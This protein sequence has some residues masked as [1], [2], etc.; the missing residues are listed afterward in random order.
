[1]IIK[2]LSTQA[3]IYWEILKF[4]ATQADE[5]DKADLQPYLNELLHALLSDKA[6]CFVRLDEDRTI[7]ALMITRFV[8]DKITGKKYLNMQCVYSFKKVEDTVWDQ[9]FNV[10]RKFADNEQCSH[11]SFSSRNERIWNL[12][13]AI[14]FKEVTRTFRFK[15]GSNG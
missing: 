5:V 10:I 9:D 12:T 14:G 11:I 2:L 8:V 15:G 13:K 1:M 3:P 4:A 6:Q 7:T